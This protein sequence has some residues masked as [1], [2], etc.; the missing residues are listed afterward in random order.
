MATF[1]SLPPLDPNSRINSGAFGTLY[2]D[3]RNPKHCI[4][5]LKT[6]LNGDEARALV[7]LAEVARWARPSDSARLSTRFAWPLEVFGTNDEVHGYTMPLAPDSCFFE[8][9]AAKR[10]RRETLQIKFLTDDSYWRSAAISSA[11]PKVGY[12]DRLEIAIDCLDSIEVLHRHGLSYGDISGNNVVARLDE[13]PGVFFFDA[14]SIS[15]LELRSRN[16][17]VSPGWETP[18]GLDPISI[19]RSRFAILVIRLL[20]EE[21]NVFPDW[22][23]VG[24][25]PNSGKE[26][27]GESLIRCYFT[28]FE[29]DFLNLSRLMRESRDDW[30]DERAIR[31]AVDAGFARWLLR[32]RSEARSTE[33]K[34]HIALAELQVGYETQIDEVTGLEYRKLL[35][36]ARTLNGGFVLD[37]RPR[38]EL[39]KAPTTSAE[40][41]QLVYDAMFE[42]ITSH[43]SVA[44]LGQLESDPWMERA[45]QHALLEVEATKIELAIRPGEADVLFRWPE[46]QFVNCARLE[47]EVGGRRQEHL[48]RR[49][50]G[51][52]TPLRQ[53]KAPQ[54][55]AGWVS[56]CVGS[57]SPSGR[58]FYSSDI[59]QARFWVDQV[60]VPV[61]T[62]RPS[63]SAP[64]NGAPD[65]EFVDP[66]EEERR[67]VE[68]DLLRR[69]KRRRI[70]AL[71]AVAVVLLGVIGK[72]GFDKFLVDDPVAAQPVRL[73]FS[74]DEEMRLRLTVVGTSTFDDQ[75]AV[76]GSNDGR[77][78]ALSEFV[79]DVPLSG[80]SVILESPISRYMRARY[81]DGGRLN[82]V[83]AIIGAFPTGFSEAP[84]IVRDGSTVFA[85]WDPLVSET[86]GPLIRFE[87]EVLLERRGERK[88]VEF[89]TQ[90]SYTSDFTVAEDQTTPRFRVRA[91]FSDGFI[92]PVQEAI[93]ESSELDQ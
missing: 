11:K 45:V 31:E 46:A 56:L 81:L 90:R 9:T 72:L 74:L 80:S 14:D 12:Q 77:S 62:I 23:S 49:G 67:R 44:G 87:Y 10:T 92:G 83:E 73:E 63:L 28:G 30:R 1:G 69:K 38:L 48:V 25:L 75:I 91:I 60:P 51:S 71:S 79:N 3:P 5:V 47:I 85:R 93:T 76:F 6:P 66:V 42:E 50:Q 78:W 35:R 65:F 21:P 61:S 24:R 52:G 54:G 16:P 59:Q 40:L 29:K 2:L 82:G 68:A 89:Q 64:G 15:P 8:L 18:D 39:V 17:L 13:R 55:C 20:L 37:I 84:V 58:I 26:Q 36:R 27:F 32:E 33:E 7:R 22:D 57:E 88:W 4:K 43:L 19:D 41:H 86:H 34:R 53:I 70:I